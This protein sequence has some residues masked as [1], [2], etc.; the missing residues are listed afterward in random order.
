MADALDKYTD[1][2]RA[3][4]ELRS[5]RSAFDALSD[6]W[7]A[8]GGVMQAVE[9]DHSCDRTADDVDAELAKYNAA[10]GP[11]SDA[12]KDAAYRRVT[13][14]VEQLTAELRA[15]AQKETP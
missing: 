11:L 10:V 4:L 13:R 14:A 7:V 12:D 6:R 1:G 5:I 15:L 9:W 2:A 3:A 8:L